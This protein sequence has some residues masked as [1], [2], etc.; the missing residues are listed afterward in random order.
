MGSWSKFPVKKTSAFLLPDQPGCYALS[1]AGR[2]VYVGMSG[3][4][5][6]RLSAHGIANVPGPNMF[7]GWVSTPWGNLP[8]SDGQLTGRVRVTE[9]ADQA[10]AIEKKLI[11]R[12]NPQF[13]KV[14]RT[15]RGR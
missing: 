11:A 4:L 3:C 5:R 6:D 13:N 15:D 12:L 14:G 2:V 10:L 1:F 8:W 9:T 7:D